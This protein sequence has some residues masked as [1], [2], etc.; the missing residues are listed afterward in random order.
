MHYLHR[1]LLLAFS[2]N[3]DNSES[4]LARG[5][6][7]VLSALT[8]ANGVVRPDLNLIH[9]INTCCI[10]QCRAVSHVC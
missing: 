3:D 1:F 4:N 9:V 8:A 2:K 10:K 5:R 6:I 7:V